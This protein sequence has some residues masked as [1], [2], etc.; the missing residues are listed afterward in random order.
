M[1]EKLSLNKY[2]QLCYEFEQNPSDENK[3]AIDEYLSK[4]QI[5][6]YITMK[7][8][9]M[10]LTYILHSVPGDLDEPTTAA[11]L[12]MAKIMY[13]LLS[14]VVNIE[15]DLDNIIKTLYPVYDTIRIHGLYDT[16]IS[17]CREDFELFS[18]MLDNAL[19]VAHIEK[20]TGTVALLSDEEYDKWVELMA[21]VK[22]TLKPEMLETLMKFN[23]VNDEGLK[24]LNDALIE[25]AVEEANVEMSRSDILAQDASVKSKVGNKEE[26]DE[27]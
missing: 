9:I 14:Y 26:K 7:T 23:A 22:D 13:G 21:E 2:L 8:K 11:Y 6:N 15:N 24:G 17:V 25:T 3:Q 12:E 4:L 16:I 20:L 18:K 27:K 1:E 10:D 19:N 5:K